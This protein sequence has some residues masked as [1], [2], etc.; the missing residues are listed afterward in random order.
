M[1]LSVYLSV[2]L[3]LFVSFCV[4]LCLFV[5]FCV[6]LCNLITYLLFQ[7]RDLLSTP[8]DTRPG[9]E[10]RNRLRFLQEISFAGSGISDVSIRLISHQLPQLTHIDL[11]HCHKITDFGINA[12]TKAYKLIKLNLSSCSLISDTSL[13]HLRRCPSLNYLDMRECHQV[14]SLACNKFVNSMGKKFI[15]KECKLMEV[16]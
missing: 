12:L 13:D 2:C 14:T 8:S 9:V 6:F 7:V 5:S 1:C 15:L 10:Q 16:N 4:F 11:S 3:C